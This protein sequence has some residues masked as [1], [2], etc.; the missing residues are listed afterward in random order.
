MPI[1]NLLDPSGEEFNPLRPRRKPAAPSTLPAPTNLPSGEDILR[2]FIRLCHVPLAAKIKFGVDLGVD[3]NVDLV[4][5]RPEECG[6]VGCK[7]ERVGPGEDDEEEDE[8]EGVTPIGLL[9]R[10]LPWMQNASKTN[11][12]AGAH[13]RRIAACLA[14]NDTIGKARAFAG[15]RALLKGVVTKHNTVFRELNPARGKTEEQDRLKK[16][17]TYVTGN[18][19]FT[20]VPAISYKQV[21]TQFLKFFDKYGVEKAYASLRLFVPAHIS[22]DHAKLTDVPP[23]EYVSFMGAIATDD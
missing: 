23:H 17:E 11:G 19:V 1:L 21:Q 4:E 2:T 8:D 9:R 6:V 22:P 7:T 20:P 14:R 12:A 18:G 3:P 13:A 10:L 5:V 16:G 15:S